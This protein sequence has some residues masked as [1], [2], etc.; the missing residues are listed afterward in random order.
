MRFKTFAQLHKALDKAAA[1]GCPGAAA[2]H[3]R[4]FN[5]NAW[6][7]AVALLADWWA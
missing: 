2:G 5:D 6:R 1:E 7:A 4:G 3:L